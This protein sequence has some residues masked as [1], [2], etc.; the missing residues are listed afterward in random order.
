MNPVDIFVIAIILLSGLFAFATG[1]VK[2][3]L[4]V[5]AWVG[6]GVV[7]AY[8]FPW[9]LPIAER[10]LPKGIISGLAAVAA[11]FVAALIVLSIVVSAIGSATT[12]RLKE[13]GLSAI[14]R[15]LGLLFGLVRGF[16]IACLLYLGVVSAMSE[17]ERP[18]WIK[19]ARSAPM[20]E[21]GATTLSSMIP[22]TLRSRV[23][24]IATDA[25]R[26]IDQDR[27]ADSATRALQTPKP[28]DPGQGSKGGGADSRRDMNR[29]FQQNT[30]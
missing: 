12:K 24:A 17:A 9:A 18:Q 20:L 21:I 19:E 22:V 10:F 2:E 4:W 6:A 29:L 5:G 30:Q 8:A 3:L 15:T 25:A 1:F 26:K 14:D 7:T 23:E 27:Q 11:V 13:V 28:P 16:V